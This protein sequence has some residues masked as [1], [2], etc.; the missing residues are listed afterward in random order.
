M[1]MLI[2]VA[3]PML[4]AIVPAHVFAVPLL[5]VIKGTFHVEPKARPACEAVRGLRVAKGTIHV[6]PTLMMH[7][8][9]NG[10]RR[11]HPR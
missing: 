1:R 5:I 9:G 6:E 8:E 2:V 11:L 3:V 4:I 7:V 10:A